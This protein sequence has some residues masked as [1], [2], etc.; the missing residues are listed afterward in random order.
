[1]IQLIMACPLS[2]AA[3]FC[4]QNLL[5]SHDEEAERR[6]DPSGLGGFSIFWGRLVRVDILKVLPW[7]RLTFYGPKALQIRMAMASNVTD[8][9]GGSLYKHQRTGKELGYL[10]TPPTGKQRAEGWASLETER[11]L[12]LKFD[13]P[14]RP[15]FD[16]AISGLGWVTVEPLCK[17]LE[18]SE[19]LLETTSKELHLSIRVP[20]PVEIFIRPPMPVG[21]AGSEWYQ[22]RELTELDKKPDLNGIFERMGFDFVVLGFHV[23]SFCSETLRSLLADC[24]LRTTRNDAF[25]RFIVF[26]R[27]NLVLMHGIH[28]A[29]VRI[30]TDI[31]MATKNLDGKYCIDLG[32]SEEVYRAELPIG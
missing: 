23:H 12:Q 1:M 28:G 10:L 14:E 8:S 32:G 18:K 2:S 22:Y 30:L 31:A 5:T 26:V 4:S 19:S 25:H 9:Y 21:K 7:T 15:A 16:V 11:K 3:G 20:K 17:T 27:E 29:L 13:D 6:I 24:K